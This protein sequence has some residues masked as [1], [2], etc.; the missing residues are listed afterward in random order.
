MADLEQKYEVSRSRA[1]GFLP[2]KHSEKMNNKTMEAMKHDH[3]LRDEDEEKARERMMNLQ[4]G[5]DALVEAFN[6]RFIKGVGGRDMRLVQKLTPLMDKSNND[7][8]HYPL[9][10]DADEKEMD[11]VQ[12]LRDSVINAD[13]ERSKYFTPS[14]ERDMIR[15]RP[16]GMPR[17]NQPRAPPPSPIPVKTQHQAQSTI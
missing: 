5:E 6:P 17:Y 4:Y 10:P 12:I 11:M 16:R 13:K 2:I 9:Y 1:F 14:E 8:L 15:H 3:L 7:Q